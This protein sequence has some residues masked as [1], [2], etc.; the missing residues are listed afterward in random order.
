M[1]SCILCVGIDCIDTDV[2]QL[3][4]MILHPRSQD[5]SIFCLFNWSFVIGLHAWNLIGLRFPMEPSFTVV[6]QIAFFSF[7]AHQNLIKLTLTLFSPWCI[8]LY[9]LGFIQRWRQ[10]SFNVG[11]WRFGA[12]HF[13]FSLRILY[14]LLFTWLL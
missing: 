10:S 6:I 9:L 5:I 13:I 14:Y 7:G 3:I 8:H 1:L 2:E 11:V 4:T 12:D